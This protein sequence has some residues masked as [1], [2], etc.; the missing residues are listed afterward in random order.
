MISALLPQGTGAPSAPCPIRRTHLHADDGVDEERHGDEQT[1]VGQGLWRHTEDRAAPGRAAQL[2]CSG[3]VCRV[4]GGRVSGATQTPATAN[5]PPLTMK[6]LHQET[7]SVPSSIISH[8]THLR[9][10]EHY[11]D[12]LWIT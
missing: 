9:V 2:P 11:Q 4:D 12:A 3:L 10:S 5:P 8:R 7:A 1:H 6:P